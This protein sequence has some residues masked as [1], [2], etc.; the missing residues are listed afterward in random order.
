MTSPASSANPNGASP[1]GRGKGPVAALCACEQHVLLAVGH[2]AD[3]PELS[4]FQCWKAK[5]GAMGL[6]APAL[7]E[8]LKRLKLEP[9]DLGGLAVA[10]GPGS[11]SGIRIALSL[12]GG[13]AAGCGLPVAGLDYLPLLAA[14][15]APFH[16]G[17]LAVITRARRNQ[18]YFQLFSTGTAQGP[19]A[20]FN[21]QETAQALASLPDGCA[22]LG[23]GLTANPT[24]MDHL[25]AGAVR[26]P[27]IVDIPSGLA[28]LRSAKSAEFGV[29]PIEPLYVRDSDAEENL[30][31]L[32]GSRGLDVAEARVRLRDSRS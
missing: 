24:L 1:D 31:S 32:V 27:S 21:V 14:T 26:L 22:V 23:S 11:F 16:D 5:A 28:L 19:L 3:E 2:L 8:C 29:N 20:V 7:H 9:G 10:R 17:P 13:L 15:A 6:M 18:L 30:A 4:A 12:A 25:P